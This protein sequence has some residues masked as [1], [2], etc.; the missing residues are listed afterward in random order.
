MFRDQS[1]KTFH[2]ESA[3]SYSCM[4]TSV[5]QDL[6]AIEPLIIRAINAITGEGTG[7]CL[8]SATVKSRAPEELPDWEYWH[9]EGARR[10][11]KT[12]L[13]N[14]NSRLPYVYVNIMESADIGSDS[15]CDFLIN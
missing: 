7:S 1:K 13:A 8:V 6:I 4:H 2:L 15:S 10:M 11:V 12:T 3:V 5:L 14:E 9:N